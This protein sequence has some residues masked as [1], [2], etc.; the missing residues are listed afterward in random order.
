MGPIKHQNRPLQR[1]VGSERT[2]KGAALSR[3][4]GRRLRAFNVLLWERRFFDEFVSTDCDVNISIPRANGKSAIASALACSVI[5]PDGP[6]HNAGDEITL[7]A[8]SHRQAG[9]VFE[10]A[11]GLLQNKTGLSRNEW[12]IANTMNSSLIEHRAS[13]SRLRCV[14][15]DPKKM[16][17]LRSRWI[18]GDEAASWDSGKVESAFAAVG[19]SLGKRA[20]SRRILIGT[21]PADQDHPFSKALTDPDCLSIIYAADPDD[22]PLSWSTV[23]KANPSLGALPNL[24]KR[25]RQELKIA[26]R[27]SS[28]L[29]S[30]RALRLNMGVSDCDESNHVLTADSWRSMESETAEPVGPSFWGVDTAEGT[31]LC[32]VASFWPDSGR[33]EVVSCFPNIPTLKERGLRDG[34][35]RLYQDC[36]QRGELILLGDHAPDLKALIKEALSRFG[37]PVRVVADRHR[38]TL[39]Q[40]A[41][42]STIPNVP[43]IARGQGYIDGSEHVRTFR[44]AALEGRVH[45]VTSLLMRSAVGSARVVSDAAGNSKLAKSSQGGRRVRSR[46]DAIAAGIMAVWAGLHAPAYKP[47]MSYSGI[48]AGVSG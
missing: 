16:H 4:I 46:D 19:T 36:Q 37:R 29:A 5:D 11:L 27:D 18:I 2:Q 17:G 22:D 40:D 10:D 38:F 13:G 21:R 6:N 8:A 1:G 14:G 30:W 35:G 15:S 44:R 41:I 20:G 7:V 42:A 32:A 39:L 47:A 26:S 25:L 48:M 34:V 9:I 12:R 45:P 3:Y 31:S 43:L 33:L 23:R 28:A 24:R